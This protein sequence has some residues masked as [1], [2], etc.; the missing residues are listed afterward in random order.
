ML[1][2]ENLP[3]LII[4][5]HFFGKFGKFCQKRVFFQQ[6]VEIFLE[7]SSRIR[8][9]LEVPKKAPR[10]RYSYAFRPISLKQG[11][12]AIVDPDDYFRLNEQKWCA[13]KVC[14]KFYAVRVV[15]Q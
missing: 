2:K 10:I 7:K 15:R 11:K 4:F 13:A 3:K 12:Y 6:M 1:V 9:C 8:I 14:R 5:F